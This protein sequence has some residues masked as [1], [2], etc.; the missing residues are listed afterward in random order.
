MAA[1]DV[2]Q[3]GVTATALNAYLALQPGAGTEIVVHNIA[4]STDAQLEWYD[5][6]TGVAIDIQIGAGGWVGGFFHC[7]NT[8]YYR[9]K[10]TNAA[11]NNLCADGMYTK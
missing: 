3:L 4:H 7:T 2:Y 1:G 5:G 9:V 8:K 10:N 11:S 6:S